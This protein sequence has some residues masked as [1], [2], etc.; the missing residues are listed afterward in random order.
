MRWV[1]VAGVPPIPQRREGSSHYL[2]AKVFWFAGKNEQLLLTGSA[3]PSVAAFFAPTA[4]RNAEAVVVD[5]RSGAADELGIDALVG[6]PPIT[7]ADWTTIT[8]RRASQ[9]PPRTEPSRRIFVATPTPTGFRTQD[10]LPLCLVL[11]GVGDGNTA[12]GGAIVQEPTALVASDA[13]RD[14][15]RY[16]EGESAGEH[17][18]VLVHRTEDIA[19][20]IGGDTRKALRQ[21]LGALEEDPSQLEAL[22]KLTEKVIFDSD[23]IVRTNPPRTT[24]A[25]AEFKEMAPPPSSLALDAAG[26][27]SAR[28]KRTLASGDILVLLDAL[29]RRLGEG[30]PSNAAPRPRNDQDE[31]GADEE[32]GGELAHEVPDFELLAKACRSKVRRLIKR[33][34]GQLKLA[35]APDR[36]RRGVVQLAAVLGVVRTL[37]LVGQRPE[38]RRAQLTL[39]NPDDEWR[40]F[41]AA[42]LAVAWGDN[43]LTPRAIAEAGDDWFDEL[44]MVIGLLAWLAWDVG[45]DAQEAANLSGLQGVED[46]HWYSV[47]LLATLGPWIDGDENALAALDDSVARTPRYRVDPDRWVQTHRALLDAYVQAAADPDRQEQMGRSPR[48]GDLVLLNSR[49]SQRVRVVLA[50][51]PGSDGEKVV[52]F[53]PEGKDGE[54]AFQSS[55]VATLPWTPPSV[56]SAALA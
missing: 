7:A 1:N 45:V 14:G 30:L 54:R 36:A 34:E 9:P 37:R 50:V 29:M 18:L 11:R 13:V 21:A 20:N 22:L 44:S 15:A 52:F 19:K 10:T 26:R 23:D 53:D 16:L 6:A 8:A 51:R 5:R 47:Q 3:N 35:T 12:L 43:A 39:V 56:S 49:E 40:L 17:L 55:R 42:V 32:D 27:K 28:R 48:P 2:H 41:E 46:D 25:P 38:W 31:I 24:S 4:G 33:M